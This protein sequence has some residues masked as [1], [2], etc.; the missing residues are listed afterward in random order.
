MNP[1]SPERPNIEPSTTAAD[2]AEVSKSVAQNE[3]LASSAEMVT[4]Q[5]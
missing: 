2:T 3:E 1:F 5:Q 4:M